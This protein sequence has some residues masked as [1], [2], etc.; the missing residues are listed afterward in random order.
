MEI[1]NIYLIRSEAKVESSSIFYVIKKVL[2]VLL[3][4]LST[5]YLKII[6]DRENSLF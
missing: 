6:D 3:F 1:W 5:N 2:N 4:S